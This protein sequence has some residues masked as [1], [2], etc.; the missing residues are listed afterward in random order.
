VILTGAPA[1]E[2]VFGEPFFDYC[3]PS[4]TR[5]SCSTRG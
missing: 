5:P 1:F 2:R 4:Q 3:D